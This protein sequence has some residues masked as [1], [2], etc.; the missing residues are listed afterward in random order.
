M[1]RI[2]CDAREVLIH[3]QGHSC[4]DDF[5]SMAPGTDR[6]STKDAPHRTESAIFI[7]FALRW[8]RWELCLSG[9]PLRGFFR[10]MRREPH[11][12]RAASPVLGETRPQLGILSTMQTADSDSLIR[13]TEFRFGVETSAPIVVT[14][15]LTGTVTDESCSGI[16]LLLD[17][18]LPLRLNQEVGVSY[19]D[20]SGT[21]VVKY[22][23]RSADGPLRV[24]LQWKDL[25]GPHGP[26]QETAGHKNG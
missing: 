24:G 26:G 13:R 25:D 15:P 11:R 9:S 10:S 2:S 16:G 8:L 22:L 6:S 21:A 4:R 14:A 1:G 12:F 3:A 17:D 19:R 7:R 23:S 20:V 5:G 18:V